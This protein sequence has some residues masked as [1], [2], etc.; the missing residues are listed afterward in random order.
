L[1]ATP[2]AVWVSIRELNSPQQIVSEKHRA[3][4]VV[5]V[6]SFCRGI[7]EWIKAVVSCQT[8]ASK[9][10]LRQL[11]RSHGPG[12]VW[13]DRTR[14]RKCQ[15]SPETQFPVVKDR[16]FSAGMPDM[17][18]CALAHCQQSGASPDHSPI[19]F[20]N[21]T[22]MADATSP[23][24]AAAPFRP[25]ISE[26]AH[27]RRLRNAAGKFVRIAEKRQNNKNYRPPGRD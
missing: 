12:F 25:K 22:A 16:E 24:A 26:S 8:L 17:G 10:I 7:E 3:L 15:A 11:C 13:N 2:R 21:E 23:I 5:D 6:D 18:G 19:G 27:Q 20:A 9:R 4:A 14:V 1:N